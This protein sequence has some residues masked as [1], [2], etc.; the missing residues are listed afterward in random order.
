MNNTQNHFKIGDRVQI[1]GPSKHQ[2]EVVAVKGNNYSGLTYSVKVGEKRI[3]GLSPQ[4]LK[5]L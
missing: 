3:E 4:A 1:S 5:S 2:G